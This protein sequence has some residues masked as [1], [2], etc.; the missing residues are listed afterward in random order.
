[1]EWANWQKMEIT[2]KNGD[3]NG[4]GEEERM[5]WIFLHSICLRIMGQFGKAEEGFESILEK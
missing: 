4:G 2:T 1:L 3:N 5:L